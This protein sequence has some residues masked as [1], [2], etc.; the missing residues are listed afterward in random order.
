M[1]PE[2]LISMSIFLWG[3]QAALALLCIGGGAKDKV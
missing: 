2:E 1:P 3:A